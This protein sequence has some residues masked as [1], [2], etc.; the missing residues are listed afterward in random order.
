M[1]VDQA[2]HHSLGGLEVAVD[3]LVEVE[4]VHAA[5]DAGSPVHRQGGG[6]LAAGPQHLVQLALGAVLHQDAVA[7]GLSAHPPRRGTN[8]RG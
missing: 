1:S 4:V 6:D 2:L 3:D 5:G 8:H 7:R